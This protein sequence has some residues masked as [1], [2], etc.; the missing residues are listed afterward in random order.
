MGLIQV[1]VPERVWGFDSPRSHLG[2]L[3]IDGRRGPAGAGTLRRRATPWSSSARRP[4]IVGC[5]RLRLERLQVEEYAAGGELLTGLAR[6]LD[7]GARPALVISEVRM[8]KTR[9]LD[10]LRQVRGWLWTTPSLL[11]TA[12]GD[13]AVRRESEQALSTPFDLDDLMA[14]VRTF[15]P[16]YSLGP[17][18][19]R[20]G[21]L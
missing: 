16:H 10:V 13:E 8:P 6:G 1:P 3:D 9:G 18:P 2:F 20:S 5:G 12:L 21:A 4:A 11:I 7:E 15:L 19:T 14:A 17:A